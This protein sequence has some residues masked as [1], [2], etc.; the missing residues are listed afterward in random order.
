[1]ETTPKRKEAGHRLF[2]E[3]M[4]AAVATLGSDQRSPSA[5]MTNPR[6]QI[7]PP[8]SGHPPPGK[9]PE[10]RPRG[11]DLQLLLTTRTSTPLFHLPRPASPASLASDRAG[12]R[13][14][15]LSYCSR[16]ERESRGGGGEGLQLHS[17]CKLN[18]EVYI[19]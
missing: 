2:V 9:M 11:R 1:M 10:L 16:R 15:T 14:G 17:W 7:R 19:K 18:L 3:E 5:T 6:C 13:W 8:G 4:V 12:S